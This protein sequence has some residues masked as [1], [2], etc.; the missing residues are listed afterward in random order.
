M[1]DVYQIEITEEDPI[2]NQVFGIMG[3]QCKVPSEHALITTNHPAK[4]QKDVMP[5]R[6]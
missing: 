6:Y 5:Q 3:G 2:D 4:Y 1:T